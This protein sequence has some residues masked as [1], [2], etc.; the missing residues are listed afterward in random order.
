[1]IKYRYYLL[2][3]HNKETIGLISAFNYHQ[4][5]DLVSIRKRLPEDQ[6]LKIFKLE[7]VID[8]KTNIK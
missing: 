8:E 2:N 7:I 1:M 5:V 4:A 6:F 3:D